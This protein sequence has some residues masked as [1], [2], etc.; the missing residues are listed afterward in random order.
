MVY[1]R[2]RVLTL[3]STNQTSN[4][5]LIYAEY[6]IDGRIT[7]IQWD[8]AALG[9]SG[10]GSCCIFVSGTS[11]T[12]IGTN[13]V[14]NYASN[15]FGTGWKRYP[16]TYCSDINGSAFAGGSVL[17]EFVCRDSVIGIWASGM[18]LNAG[19][20]SGIFKIHYY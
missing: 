14:I 19:S 16:L 3:P 9:P 11:G 5:Y 7:K 13:E 1:E 18:G 12:A 8:R 20:N 15:C 17:T 2:T 6:P 4:N 10:A